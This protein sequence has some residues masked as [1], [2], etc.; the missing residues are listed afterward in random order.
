MFKKVSEIIELIEEYHEGLSDYFLSLETKTGDE[1]VKMLLEF[2]GKSEAFLAEYLE[3]YRKTTPNRIMNAWVKYVPWLPTDIYCE[4]RKNVNLQPP[5]N[6]YNVLNA[7]IHFDDCL[8]SFY[9]T[10]VQE[11]QNERVGE[12]FSNLL[13][14]TKK[15]EMN[16]ARDISWLHDL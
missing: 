11:I 15:H 1:R 3:T 6:T 10:L 7:A 13:R 12:I 8:I 16:L 2:L 9:T 5:L 14:V 4:C